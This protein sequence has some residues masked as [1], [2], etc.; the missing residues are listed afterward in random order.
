[1]E[2]EFKHFIDQMPS[3]IYALAQTSAAANMIIFRPPSYV[4]G[5]EVYLQDYHFVLPTSDPPPLRIERQVYQFR[6][7]K[8]L[9]FTPETR[10]FVTTDAPT[11]QYIAMNIKKDFFQEI[12]REA[13]GKVEMSFPRMENPYSSKLL[14]LICS[15]EEEV[16][17]FKGGCPLM[18]Q[19][20]STQIVIQILRETGN[21][22]GVQEKRHPVDRNYINLAM[23]YML[24][25]YNANIKIE[26]ICKQIYLS[27]YYFM[28]MFKDKT[29]QSPHEF[30]LSI[31]V[32]K[33]EEMLKKGNYSIEEVANLCGFVN[34]AHFS[35]HFK[36]VKG[37]S[38]SIYK[39]KY[40][41]MEK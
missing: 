4:V 26:D 12:A 22:N 16:N 15:L 11:R 40:F 27:P 29:G 41:I 9:P 34:T 14:N 20:I 1:M 36:R 39:R 10:M 21:D 8:L 6:K 33:A 35:N 37:I 7:G 30:L 24:T 25:Y 18:I 32:R 19:S 23:E 2:E 13:V 31:R 3:E 38:P 28:R 5:M 17:N